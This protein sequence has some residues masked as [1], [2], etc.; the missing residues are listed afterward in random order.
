MDSQ[1]ATPWRIDAH[2]HVWDLA[3]R[4]QPWTR[5]LPALNRSFGMADL[6]PHLRGAG[7]DATV[8]VQTSA[9]AD[10]TADLL[11][12][13][14]R[15]EHVRAVVGWTDVTDPGIGEALDRLREAPGGA[16]LVGVRHAVQEETDTKWLHR[17]EVRRGLQAIGAAGL[18][19]ELLVRADQLP[20]AVRTVEELPEVRFVLDHAGNPD[21]APDALAPWAASMNRLGRC[22]NVTVKLS[23]PVTR[24]PAPRTRHLA[25]Y[26]DV[27]LEQLGP[28]RLMFGSD[29]PVCLLAASYEQTVAVAASLTAR[30]S[31][32]ERAEVYGGTAA[33]WYGMK[34]SAGQGPAR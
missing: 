13:A 33:R 6:R 17:D 11:A 15:D 22:A 21:I 19:Y 2:H 27:L 25:P 31:P 20:M 10:E 24:S 8:V 26:A 18:V 5:N 16:L 29:W 9:V 32:R 1:P 14:A 30:L 7:I 4:D 28:D 12:L 23:G 34:R 3:V